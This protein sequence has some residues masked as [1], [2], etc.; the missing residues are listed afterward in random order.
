[1]DKNQF[2]DLIETLKIDKE[3]FW[4]VSSGG[5]VLRGIFPD[6]GDLDIVTT[7]KGLE[8]L[9][10]NYDLVEKGNGGYIINDKIECVAVLEKDELPYPLEEACGY[11]V[12]NILEYYDYLKTSDREKDK[13]RI[14]LVEEYIKNIDN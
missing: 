3:E 7:K 8:E 10:K 14:P 13:A 12:Q 9:K 2:L 5:L 11:F 6:A 1:M 4:I